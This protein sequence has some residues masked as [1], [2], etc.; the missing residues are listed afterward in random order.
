MHFADDLEIIPGV[1]T[2][3]IQD[4]KRVYDDENEFIYS[5]SEDRVSLR[6][7]VVKKLKKYYD[8]E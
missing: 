2:K 7:D 8:I 3:T 1:S 4:I 6:D 5:L